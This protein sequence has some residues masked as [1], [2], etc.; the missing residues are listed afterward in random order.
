[1]LQHSTLL[2]ETLLTDISGRYQTEVA[3]ESDADVA[4]LGIA[5]VIVALIAATVAFVL[6][7]QKIENSPIG[8]LIELCRAHG[9]SKAGTQLIEIS[10][11]ENDGIKP[12]HT[13]EVFRG[14][15][16]LGRAE[17]LRTEPDRAVGR[18]LRKFQK[19]QIQEDDDV[20]TKLR[21]G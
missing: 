19:G 14:E 1:M 18:V 8:L 11:G 5:V 20:A 9:V 7:Q 6:R 4:M 13:V 17:I 16:Y 3:N 21:V 10:V 15:R 12:G 2:A